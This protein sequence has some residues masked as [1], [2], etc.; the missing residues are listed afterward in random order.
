MAML[1][2]ANTTLIIL[3]VLCKGYRHVGVN[4]DLTLCANEVVMK[5]TRVIT[6]TNN[7]YHDSST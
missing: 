4:H 5:H 2:C 1:F 3:R 6:T 7:D